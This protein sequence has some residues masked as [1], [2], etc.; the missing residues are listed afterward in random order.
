MTSTPRLGLPYL[1]EGQAQ[2]EAA[3]NEALQALDTLVGLA[4]EEPPRA[5]PPA[6]ATAGTTYLVSDAPTGAW[7]GKAGYVAAFT[8]GGWRFYAPQEGM[9]AYV[10]SG[11]TA[12]VFRAGNWELGQVRGSALLMDGQQVVGPQAAPIP[13]PSGGTTVD[14]SARAVIGQILAALREHGLIAA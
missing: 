7:A 13:A 4:V 11:S 6:S 10:R 3:H 5:D 2:K 14:A 12:A 8:S 1:S 9:A